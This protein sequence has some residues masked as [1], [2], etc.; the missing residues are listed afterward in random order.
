MTIQELGLKPLVLD[1]LSEVLDI[2]S[3][4]IEVRES[5]NEILK[6][7]CSWRLEEVFDMSA[8]SIYVDV[9]LQ[10]Q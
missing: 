3:E 1:E 10:P 8:W 5:L 2:K 6:V 9:W 4:E 7:S